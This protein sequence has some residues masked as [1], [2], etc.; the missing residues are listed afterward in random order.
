MSEA[1][2]ED[3]AIAAPVDTAAPIVVP[4][5]AAAAVPEPVAPPPQPVLV[6]PPEPAQPPPAPEQPPVPEPAPTPEPE[7][8]AAEE[9]IAPHTE[10]PGLLKATEE[11]KEE[12]SKPAE[13]PVKPEEKPA[14]EAKPEETQ[15]PAPEPIK[16]EWKLPEGVSLQA[17]AFQEFEDFAQAQRLQPEVA[18]KLVD[19]HIAARQADLLAERQAQHDAFAE[20]RRNWRNEIMADEELG[21]AGFQTNQ[22]AAIRMLQLFIPEARREAFDQF[23]MT[24]GATDHPAMFRFLV[25]LAR[26]FDEPAP[27]PDPTPRVPLDGAAGRPPNAGTSRLSYSY[28]RGTARRTG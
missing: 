25:D 21:G 12:E 6:A 28:P 27:V 13:E 7:P 23:L 8:A 26:K 19:M 18:Q 5:P 24:T 16:Y 15:E 2:V 22:S 11:P 1:R 9:T 17:E 20:M 3:A 10:E 14:E 4:A